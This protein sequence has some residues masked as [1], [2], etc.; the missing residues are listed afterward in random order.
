MNPSSQLDVLATL[1]YAVFER[2]ANGFELLSSAPE[3]LPAGPISEAFPFLDVFLPDAEEFW[4]DPRG[5]STLPSDFWTQPG[6][7][8]KNLHFSATAIAGERKLLLIE[9]VGNRFEQT[10][11]LMQY[12]H[13]TK[14]ANDEIAR[15]SRELKRATEAKSEFLARMSH[16]IRTPMNALL[17][18]AELLSETSLNDEQSEYVRIFRRAGDN[19]LNVINDILDFSKIEAG[20]VELEC[21]AFDLADVVQDAVEIIGVRARAKGLCL[22]CDIRPEVPPRLMGDPG[23]LRQI[24][25]NLL[26]NA[27]KF[28]DRGGITTRVEPEQQNP[29]AGAIH[30]RVRDTGI[31]I[32]ADRVSTIFESF[33]QADSSTTR[34]YGGTGLG[35]AISKR[36]VELMGGR[37]WAESTAGEGSTIHFTARFAVAEPAAAESPASKT[38]A[39]PALGNRAL[40]ILLADDSEDNRFLVRG[41]LKDTGSVI[42]EVTNGAEVVE[43]FKNGVY[44]LILM[45][46]EM[47]VLDGYSS[48]RAVRAIEKERGASEIPILALTAHALKEARDRSME[49]GC[50]DHLTKPITKTA[51]LEAI[52]RYAPEL[53]SVVEAESWLKPVIP[54]YLEKRRADVVKL[55]AALDLGDYDTVRTLGHQMAGSGA[56]YGFA[57]ITEIGSDLEESALAGDTAQIREGIVQ[58][59]QFLSK[60]RS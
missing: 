21:V 29:G 30:F 6:A 7:D 50:T 36:F 4:A 9:R 35:L 11:Q 5:C 10:Q 26:S 46:A 32:P 3:W 48:T 41:Y 56:G 1:G 47:P 19:L 31:G 24:I 20:Q 42:D 38:K 16:E 18:V 2:S 14:L 34:K 33:T 8:G 60:I 12:A 23:R 43:K 55:K 28:T 59:E 54:A 13:E 15:L 22:N 25:L 53:P 39:L 17:G 58:L 40:R 57:K 52:G 37:I 49:A 27:V 44:D 45:D 51:L